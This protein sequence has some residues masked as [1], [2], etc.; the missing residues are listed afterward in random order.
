MDAANQRVFEKTVAQS[1]QALVEE[2]RARL[3][4]ALQSAREVSVTSLF[5]ADGLWRDRLAFT[6]SITPRE[7][8]ENIAALMVAKQGT[9]RA[10]AF[11]VAEGRTPPRRIQRAGV[12][13]IEGIFQF[14]TTV[15]RGYGV[16]RLLAGEP[17]R[18]FQLMTGLHELKGFEEKIGKR[19]PTGEAFSRN[20]GGTNWKE[21]R[22]ASQEYTDREPTVLIAGGGQAGLSLAATLGRIGVDTLVVD[23]FERVGD[24]WRQRYHSLA[25]HNDTSFNHLPYMP[26]PPSW[27]T[28]LPKDMVADWFEAYALAMEINFWTSTELV[29]GTY[30]E[31]EG[32]WNA[33]VRNTQDGTERTLRPG[34]L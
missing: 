5:A 28:Y 25:L 6:W 15:G 23:R 2:W 31:S 3:D 9:A 8:A 10:R 32:R 12:D 34:H 22:T 30:D 20:F 13:V 7:G 33:V 29:R 4:A 24:C 1:E 26:F 27:P 18:A 14:E 21:Q 19:R 17:S 16:V 11:A